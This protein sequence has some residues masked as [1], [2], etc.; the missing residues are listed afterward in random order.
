MKRVIDGKIY[1]TDTAEQIGSTESGV[2][3]D[4]RYYYEALYKTTRGRYF[5]EY[6][7][8]AMSQYAVN[9]GPNFVRGSSGIRVVDAYDALAWCERYEIDPDVIAKFFELED[10]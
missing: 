2:S 4:Y 7:G 5:I 6:I 9:Y 1:N 3:S 10:G 8:G